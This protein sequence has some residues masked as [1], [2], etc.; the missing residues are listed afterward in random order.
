MRCLSSQQQKKLYNIYIIFI[1]CEYE[2]TEWYL[3]FTHALVHTIYQCLPL[4]LSH[5]TC[6]QFCNESRFVSVLQFGV[7]L[8]VYVDKALTFVFF[9]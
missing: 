2:Y 9:E 6:S 3:V 5:C 8:N 4:H 7:I 1:W